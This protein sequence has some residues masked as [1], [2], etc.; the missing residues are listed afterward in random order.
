[1]NSTLWTWS[2]I[3]VTCAT[4][5]LSACD[6]GDDDDGDTGDSGRALIDENIAPETESGPAADAQLQGQQRTIARTDPAG[7][8]IEAFAESESL[9]TPFANSAQYRL[10]DIYEWGPC[11]EGFISECTT[12]EVPLDWRR[13]WG[14]TIELFMSRLPADPELGPSK[15][16]LFLLQGGPGGSGEVFGGALGSIFSPLRDHD[17]YV[18][19]H[20]GVGDSTRLTC[21]DQEALGTPGNFNIT[22]DEQADCFDA[23]REQWGDGLAHFNI[24]HAAVDLAFAQV[25]TRDWS[26]PS[27]IYGV[28]YGTFWAQRYLQV[29][30]H[31]ASGVVL[32]SVLPPNEMSIFDFDGQSDPVGIDLAGL[33][34]DDPVCSDK[35]GDDPWPAIAALKAALDG[36]HCPDLAL[37]GAALS[38]IGAFLVSNLT[39]RE[40]LFPLIYRIERCDTGDVEVVGHFLNAL[41]GLFPPQTELPR[42]SQLL[43]YNIAFV[44][45]IDTPVPTIDDVVEQCFG[46]TLCP[47]FSLS[48]RFVYEDWVPFE[49]DGFADRWFRS[50][51]PILALNGNLDP[52]TP[53]TDAQRIEAQLRFPWQNYVEIPQA[54]H[55]VAFT[56]PTEPA[57]PTTC[58]VE[59]IDGF[60]AQPFATPAEG[61]LDRLELID[62]AA[63]EGVK[64]ALLGTSDLWENTLAPAP[65]GI[66]SHL[67]SVDVRELG[68]RLRERSTIEV[69]QVVAALRTTR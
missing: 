8:L 44:E 10:P 29:A 50:V 55:A 61:C 67:T 31:F 5:T 65:Q 7:T 51:T 2:N 43:Q 39:L 48:A 41:N 54:P 23:L 66:A 64:L 19:E 53:H 20:R 17:I 11:P 36:G 13:P 68:R 35:L 1:M 22:P 58:G 49:D 57:T 12:F 60:F 52:Q 47:G 42:F 9:P 6:G 59:L 15:G 21:P 33:C 27:F 32:D 30:P 16:Q 4:L 40:L 14:E 62:F 3:A 63:D 45:I 69:E 56:T 34:A 25:T 18:L 46:S 37:P 28:S 26:L 24:T 38:N